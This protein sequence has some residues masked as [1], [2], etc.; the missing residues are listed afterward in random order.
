MN[1]KICGLTRPQ[2]V[3]VA[4]AAGADDLGFVFAPESPRHVADRFE[5]L[6]SAAA[7]SKTRVVAVLATSWPAIPTGFDVI[8]SERTDLKTASARF[9]VVRGRPEIDLARLGQAVQKLNPA[10][11]V[12][13]AFDPDRE[14]GTGLRVDTELALRIQE[15][16]S[17][18]MILAGG[19][20]PENVGEAIRAIQ[21]WGVDVSSGV[22]SA[23]GIKDP[24]KVR[25]FIQ[26]A[27]SAVSR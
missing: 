13:D 5:A 18:P 1:V 14:G 27:R 15:S 23:P 22:E 3:E 4:I 12:L 24:A 11:V 9:L 26:A 2:D 10:A 21:P 20:S 19:L 17:V 6:L 25:D 16:L 7:G 8:Q